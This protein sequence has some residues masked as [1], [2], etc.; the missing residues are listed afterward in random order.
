MNIVK[1]IATSLFVSSMFMQVAI[2]GVEED[3]FQ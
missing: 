3:V 1:K 2:A